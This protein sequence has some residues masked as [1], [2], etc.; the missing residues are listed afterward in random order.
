MHTTVIPF[1]YTLCDNLQKMFTSEFSP[2]DQMITVREEEEC[3]DTLW[4]SANVQRP[5]V[6]L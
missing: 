5:L 3:Q 2:I 4:I 1:G 6:L